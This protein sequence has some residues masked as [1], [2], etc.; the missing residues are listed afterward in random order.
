MVIK[1]VSY[2]FTLFCD[3][4]LGLSA[5]GGFFSRLAIFLAVC[6]FL[7]STDFPPRE[8][9]IGGLGVQA[10]GMFSLSSIRPV[11]ALLLNEQEEISLELPLDSLNNDTISQRTIKNLASAVLLLTSASLELL[12]DG[13]I[14]LALI[15]ATSSFLASE[16]SDCE[17]TIAATGSNGSLSCNNQND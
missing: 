10:G 7:G 11:V 5:D 12:R 1:N 6:C 16:G 2:L 13:L 8:N 3:W 14:V 17:E 9:C 4:F 15:G